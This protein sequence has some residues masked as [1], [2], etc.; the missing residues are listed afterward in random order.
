MTRARPAPA[1]GGVVPRL[2]AV[3]G[4]DGSGKSRIT[5]DLVAALRARGPAERRYLGL[6]SGEMGDRIKRL[7]FVGVRLERHLAAKASHAQNMRN[8]LPG[9]F[10][11][12]VMYALSR[13]R[14]AY[15]RRVV[16]LARRGV[17]IVSDRYPQAEVAGFRYDGPGIGIRRARGWLVRRLARAEQR[18]YERIVAWRPA[19]VIRL[20]VDV[21]TAQ[22]RKPDHAL[23]ELRDKIDVMARL[24]YHGATMVVIDARAPYAQV[25]AA[26][27][28]AANA[29]LAA[30][31][32]LPADAS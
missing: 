8:A 31:V 25:L 20:D 30:R 7:P 3:V 15:F 2:I 12:L 18:L 14:A 26:A 6:I 32:E 17:V 23:E 4:C 13:W 9:T 19:L 1:P 24:D 28:R 5:A 10:A 21:A 11:A 22:A 16:A 29:A 27:E